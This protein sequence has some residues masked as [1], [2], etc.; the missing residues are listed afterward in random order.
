MSCNYKF[1]DLLGEGTFGVVYDVQDS[2]GNNYAMK[3]TRALADIQFM[4]MNILKSSNHPN[5]AHT[6]YLITN[7]TCETD[8][9]IG[10]V[11]DLALTDLQGYLSQKDYP[12]TFENRLKI[13][14]D[15]ADGLRHLHDNNFLHLDLKPE[16]ILIYGS[17]DNPIAV[18]SDFGLASLLEQDKNNKSF[19]SVRITAPYRPPENFQDESSTSWDYGKYSDIWSLGAIYIQLFSDYVH[20][21]DDYI[22]MNSVTPKGYYPAIFKE[23]V[24]RSKLSNPD[25]FPRELDEL[26]TEGETIYYEESVASMSNKE[27]NELLLDQPGLDYSKLSQLLKVYKDS[28]YEDDSDVREYL[29]SLIL[30]NRKSIKAEDKWKL[31]PRTS[32]EE[33]ITKLL[34]K[35]TPTHYNEI[36]DVMDDDDLVGYARNQP[37]ASLDDIDRI[38]ILPEGSR[39]EEL[40]NYLYSVMLS[41]TTEDLLLLIKGMLVSDKNK[42]LSILD[43]LSHNFFVNLGYTNSISNNMLIPDRYSLLTKGMKDEYKIVA[44]IKENALHI[45]NISMKVDI[46]LR[47]FF[48]IMDIYYRTFTYTSFVN[49]EEARKNIGLIMLAAV[50]IGL[51]M[52][53]QPYIIADIVRM[54]NEIFGK[55]MVSVKNLSMMVKGLCQLFS[56]IFYR[57]YLWER[58]NTMADIEDILKNVMYD[59]ITYVDIDLDAYFGRIVKSDSKAEKKVDA[60]I[61]DISFFN[62]VSDIV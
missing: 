35:A 61:N 12:I 4:E 31:L 49:Y 29:L 11:S 33:I 41:Q 44:L 50:Y 36:L 37:L 27:V 1:G 22:T 20:M 18:V 16:N 57:E 39:G 25:S 2:S 8:N 15:I 52:M 51:G 19:G 47:T 62:E 9:G 53:D 14:W 30:E 46:K 55:G 17:Y 43:V 42:R 60:Y 38:L 21:I 6:K 56:G 45:K 54:G 3:I 10:Y 34:S 7:G 58:A 32:Y 48:V 26:L 23:L 40:K 59:P 24:S 28:K 13:A 5:V